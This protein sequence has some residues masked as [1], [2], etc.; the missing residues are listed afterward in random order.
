MTGGHGSTTVSV[1]PSSRI[2]P[3]GLYAVV[4]D[5]FMLLR[6]GGHPTSRADFTNPAFS[7]ASPQPSS[8]NVPLLLEILGDRWNNCLENRNE[9]WN[10]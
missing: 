4:S 7:P 9:F 6:A 1:Q 2:T 10:G 3:Y 5:H 8:E